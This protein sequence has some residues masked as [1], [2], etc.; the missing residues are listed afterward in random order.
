MEKIL[1]VKPIGRA[2]SAVFLLRLT[3]ADVV[4]LFAFA[5]LAVG[6]FQRFAEAYAHGGFQAFAS[7]FNTSEF[8]ALLA[9]YSV[10]KSELHSIVLSK[11][12]FGI[13]AACALFLLLPI[14]R[15]P[16]IGATAAGLYFWCRSP[17]G[18]HLASVG[19]LLLAISCYELWG[20]VF[21]KIVSAPV[22]QAEV[23]VISNLGQRLG[24]NL[25]LDGIILDSPNGWSIFM[26]EECS[27][28]HNISLAVLVWLSL[29]KL[30]GAKAT[31]LTVMALCA[32]ITGIICLNALRVLLMTP[33]EEA[34]LFWHNGNGA[35][36]FS[37]VTLAVIAFPTIT[38]MQL[39]D[40]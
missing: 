6:G 2:R 5:F 27:S 29:I 7:M 36:I 23:S 20:P 9:I 25:D 10:C 34:Y 31:C 16:L 39:R 3:D 24:Y 35:I 28:F 38:S 4:L 8:L 11:F 14:P 40:V 1:P 18:A 17:R 26:M 33:S 30:G 19:Q 12:D 22:I 15:L 37:C 13:I 21:F 32:G